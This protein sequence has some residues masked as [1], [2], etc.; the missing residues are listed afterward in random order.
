MPTNASSE[1]S[2]TIVDRG[3][4]LAYVCAYRLMR[5]YWRLRRPETH[6]T[7]VLLFHGGEV[8]LVKNSYV[9]YYSAPGGYVRRGETSRDAVLRELKEEIGVSVRPEQLEL[10]LDKTHDWEGKHDHVEIFSLDV[11]ARPPMEIDHREVVE[12]SWFTFERALGLNLFP[13]LRE[14]ITVRS[15][16]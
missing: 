5:V 3:F 15:A 1:R 9:P 2:P 8:L 4:Q 16:R 14:V 10:S 12:A 13:P 6:G 7:L 11:E